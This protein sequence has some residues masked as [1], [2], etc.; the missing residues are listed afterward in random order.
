MSK[1]YGIE[2]KGKKLMPTYVHRRDLT[3]LDV[4]VTILY[5]GVCHSDKHHILND[6][7]DT[8]YP[9]VPGHEIVGVV[10]AVGNSV[11][12]CKVGD[13]VAV[14]TMTD[15]CMHCTNC[16]KGEEQYCLQGGPTW[17]YNGRERLDEKGGR[18][19]RPEGNR[20]YGGYSKN[21]VVQ[22]HFVY[23]LPDNLDLA[24]CAPL[25]CAGI[26]TF[27]PLKEHR[28]GKGHKVGIAG[29][30]GLGHLAIKFAKA[31]GAEVVALTTSEWKLSSSKKLGADDS[32]LV[33]QDFIDALNAMDKKEE[34]KK[35]T[36]RDTLLLNNVD[37]E[38][39]GYFD[40]IISTIPVSHDIT[41]YLQLLTTHG[42]LHLLGNF[43]SYPNLSGS[44]F[45]PHGKSITSSV[46]GGTI[47]TREMLQF[48]SQHHIEADIQLI[49]IK[50]INNAIKSLSNNNVKYRY[51][52]D[53]STL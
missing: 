24:K 51:V 31:L 7:N 20:T 25:L 21:I 49:N 5:C 45:I 3:P 38:Y 18:Y 22:E 48:C 9:L 17:V 4:M 14:G 50:N 29:I 12:H 16:H 10:D 37:L 13:Y 33:N 15:S 35:L 53:M 6:W 32:V 44:K 27:T 39:M 8:I 36:K 40:L 28:I 43:N 47:N 34:E 2:A 1:A 19:L 42:K 11:T 52:I 26:T 23:L 30:G 46:A 41:P